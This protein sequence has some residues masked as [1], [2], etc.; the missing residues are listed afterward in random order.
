M[1]RTV[2]HVLGHELAL[3][4]KM[5][6]CVTLHQAMGYRKWCRERVKTLGLVEKLV[7]KTFGKEVC[8][9]TTPRWN[10][11]RVSSVCVRGQVYQ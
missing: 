11:G 9:R 7:I 10:K 2:E 1:G 4:R 3:E 6:K 8:G 5:A